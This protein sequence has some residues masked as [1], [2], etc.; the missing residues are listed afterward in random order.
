MTSGWGLKQRLGPEVGKSQM[1]AAGFGE[2]AATAAFLKLDHD[3][4][5]GR[6]GEEVDCNSNST[7][8]DRARYRRRDSD[9]QAQNCTDLSR[10]GACCA[11]RPATPRACVAFTRYH[12]LCCCSIWSPCAAAT[13]TIVIP[14]RAACAMHSAILDAVPTREMIPVRLVLHLLSYVKRSVGHGGLPDEC[15]CPE[16]KTLMSK[17]TQSRVHMDCVSRSSVHSTSSN[18]KI[19]NLSR[20][21]LS[22]RPLQKI[23][24]DRLEKLQVSVPALTRAAFRRAVLR[25]KRQ[26]I[27]HASGWRRPV[28]VAPWIIWNPHV[29]K[30]FRRY[31]QSNN[32]R[33][34]VRDAHCL[35]LMP[36]V[37]VW[38][39]RYLLSAARNASL[40]R[41]WLK[42]WPPNQDAS[43]FDLR[44]EP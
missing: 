22:R 10:A 12:P 18:S 32:G 38:V 16:M 30:V 20:P 37:H 7:I 41:H 14:R 9:W 42:M 23:T 28:Q 1:T 11:A 4:G 33:R 8:A 35:L 43:S 3:G 26:A 29:N 5:H 21:A 13:S 25:V 27:R 34:L 31:H 44:T 24:N 17:C 2:Y 39:I 6:R 36:D 19:S 15:A 40:L